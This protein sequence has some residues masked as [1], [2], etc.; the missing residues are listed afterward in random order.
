MLY[1]LV[2]CGNS[3][4]VLLKY[5]NL[6]PNQ[7]LI[8]KFW[9]ASNLCNPSYAENMLCFYLHANCARSHTWHIPYLCA[10]Q[11]CISSCIDQRQLHGSYFWSVPLRA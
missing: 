9:L 3:L 5:R 1:K 11:A 4:A 2:R 7:S 10:V 8:I 6:A